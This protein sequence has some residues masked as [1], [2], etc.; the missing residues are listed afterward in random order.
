MR[1]KK[2]EVIPVESQEDMKANILMKINKLT[3]AIR[4]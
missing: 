4:L 3:I 1:H 2:K